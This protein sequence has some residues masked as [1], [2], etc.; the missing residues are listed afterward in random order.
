M[1]AVAPVRTQGTA[2]DLTQIVDHRDVDES[3]LDG[4]LKLFDGHD[5]P[6]VFWA[7]GRKRGFY[8]AAN[9]QRRVAFKAHLLGVILVGAY[10][11]RG[12]LLRCGCPYR[13]HTCDGGGTHYL[14]LDLDAHDG[15][16]DTQ[17]RVTA[18][19]GVCHRLRLFPLVATSRS[20]RGAHVFLFFNRRVTT[21]VANA[22]G[23]IIAE[24]AGIRDRCDVIPSAGHYKG[25]GTLHA[26][27]L[28]PMA[29][30]GG[31]L[32]LD[33][34]LQ[35]LRGHAV[36]HALRW[37]DAWR[38]DAGVVES[39]VSAPKSKPQP[40]KPTAKVLVESR[41]PAAS[42]IVLSAVLKHHPQF[43][44]VLMMDPAE[45]RGKRSSRDTYLV[46]YLRRQGFSSDEIARILL[47]TPGTKTAE[48]GA[49]YAIAIV[50]AQDA[51]AVEVVVPLAGSPA[52]FLSA[53]EPWSTRVAPPMAYD[54]VD[55]PWWSGSVQ[56]RLRKSMAFDRVVLAY[57]VDRY[58]RGPIRRRMFFASA[59]AIGEALELSPR[60]VAHAV[61]RLA[62]RF[63]DVLRVV[64]GVPHP[65]LRIATAYYVVDP[66]HN[67]RL[68]WRV[69]SGRSEQEALSF[70]HATSLAIRNF[71][72]GLEHVFGDRGDLSQD[73]PDA[74]AAGLLGGR[75]GTVL[76]GEPRVAAR[77]EG[78]LV[79][80]LAGAPSGSR[81]RGWAE[82]RLPV[83]VRD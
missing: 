73:A 5:V 50:E 33:S 37:A 20:G 46:G 63:S 79:P 65:H 48:R 38:S 34:N 49:E 7:G 14:C 18:I 52:P 16:T 25:F 83:A 42:G 2:A 10:P 64:P 56:E 30:P 80:G 75:A 66:T 9:L 4:L 8:K 41:L 71:G 17:Q 36:A 67:D 29:E 12:V 40:C 31:G 15:E 32:I 82:R 58:F 1:A 69:S 72:P 44:R 62:D 61:K 6:A 22:A 27:P 74:D 35:P 3:L 43:R 45:W 76:P 19:L 21:A 47:N 81:A 28:T 55:N 13:K 57:L 53:R 54:G 23:R 11:F 24:E 26:L 60:T 39:L 70:D 68:D 77:P 78:L 51:L 59:R